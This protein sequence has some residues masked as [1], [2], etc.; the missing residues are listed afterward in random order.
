LKGENGI[1]KKKF[2]ALQKDIEDQK[3]NIK[4]MTEEEGK[5]NAYIE[6]LEGRIKSHKQEIDERDK[7]IGEKEKQIYE[8][9]KNNQELEKFKFVLDYQIKELKRQIEPRENEIADMKDRVMAMDVQL[10]TYH[11]E[12]GQLQNEVKNLKENLNHKQNSIRNQR[13]RL[14]KASTSLQAMGSDLHN[15]VQLIQSPKE[16]R[17]GTKALYET[18]VT[19][20]IQAEE[21]DP[22][23]SKE[24]NRQKQYLERSVD[25]LK[26][27]LSKDMKARRN[28]NMRVMQEN[29]ALIK[30]INKMR[31][32][33]KLLHQM[34]R[35]N[36]LHS[37]KGDPSREWATDGA[38][39]E[40]EALKILQMQ[41]EQIEAFRI[42]I[43]S[44]TAELSQLR[45]GSR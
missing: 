33:I 13:Q 25:V 18:H 20:R 23:V 43:G 35:Q 12:N 34:E 26:H 40:P 41:R 27:K 38:W 17:S 9:K 4:E 7:T 22:S 19:E 44:T 10:E 24:Y 31:R 3:E 37:S 29:V 5:L 42:Q 36:E 14:R 30:D 21:V 15:L 39:D 11:K 45:T 6:K 1:M 2:S 16:L 28:D 8:L 32:E